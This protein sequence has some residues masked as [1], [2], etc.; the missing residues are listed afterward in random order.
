MAEEFLD[1]V[2]RDGAGIEFQRL[3]FPF[4]GGDATIGC[5]VDGNDLRAFQPFG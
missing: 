5:D 1:G 2:F 3:D 4:R